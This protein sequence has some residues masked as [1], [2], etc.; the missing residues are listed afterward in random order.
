MNWIKAGRRGGGLRLAL[1]MVGLA[2]AVALSAERLW[3]A[4]VQPLWFD[5]A[6][7]LAIATAPDWR[8]VV[9]E[10]WIDVN[11]PLFYALAHAWTAV[12]G[13]SDLALRIPALAAVLIAAA[14]PLVRRVEGLKLEGR[15]ALSILILAWWGVDVFLA[16]RCYGL[17]LALTTAQTLAFADLARA[18][19]GRRA[20]T[21]ASLAAL[22]IL[23]HY[24]AAIL[25]AVQGLAYLASGRRA[26]LKTWP[27]ALAFAPA[28]AWIA[29]HAPR[30]KAYAAGDVAWHAALGADQAAGMAGFILDPSAPALGLVAALVLGLGFLLARNRA[31]DQ[32]TALWLAAGCSL[33]ALALTLASGV[34]RPSLTARYLIP[35]A[36]GLLL[37]LVLMAQGMRR[38]ALATGGLVIVYLASALW[39]GRLDA[40]LRSQSPYGFE[41]A[42]AELTRQGVS[43]VAFAWDHEVT[44]LIPPDTLARLGGVFFRRAGASVRMHP[45]VTRPGD[46]VNR[47]ALAAAR[48]PRP[49][50]I[51]IYN[52]TGRTAAA[53]HPPQIASVDPRWTC[54]RTGDESI[55]ALACWRR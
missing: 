4:A 44:A 19:G 40:G 15:L 16:G 55:G 12:A 8:S 32:P 3:L 28:L 30:L 48:G 22:S 23:T 52:R 43:D 10:A 46:D 51:W 54:R 36:P 14:L 38:P 7:T 2:A 41:A 24:Y 50:I 29:W 5:E 47:L 25:V 1:A 34:L 11:A 53:L 49:G 35:A 17:L 13:S 9:H 18:P 42:S 27:A 20:W 6:W 21:W 39:P 31:A 37:G 26:A 45:V 33:V